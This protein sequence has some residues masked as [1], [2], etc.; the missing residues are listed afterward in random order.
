MLAYR[1]G[2]MHAEG[3]KECEWC[4]EL[5]VD[6]IQTPEHVLADCRGVEGY[7]RQLE[8]L[9]GDD[10]WQVGET[11]G[12]TIWQRLVGDI[13]DTWGGLGRIIGLW[14]LMAMH[15]QWVFEGDRWMGAG[16]LVE[17]WKEMMREIIQGWWYQGRRNG[18]AIPKKVL[19]M[20]QA[21]QERMVLSDSGVR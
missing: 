20:I 19:K 6:N 7:W 5:G 16:A 3:K 17:R 2:W 4:E 1:T 15:W 21:S 11:V 14:V 10:R 9:W 8:S 13:G 18:E 12:S